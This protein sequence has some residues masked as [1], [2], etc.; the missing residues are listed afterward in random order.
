[1]DRKEK[2][3]FV[4]HPIRAFYIELKKI[5]FLPSTLIGIAGLQTIK[6]VFYPK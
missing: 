4:K 6:K 2:S 5:N 3:W 1:V